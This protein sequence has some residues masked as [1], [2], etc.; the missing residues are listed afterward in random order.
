M[1][2]NSHDPSLVRLDRSDGFATITIDDPATR[3]AL[4]APVLAGLSA[5]CATVEGDADV[6][7]VVVRG[8]GDRVFV[9]GGNIAEVNAAVGGDHNS[10]GAAAMMALET[11]TKPV[12]AAINGHCLGGGLLVALTADLRVAV[13]KA[14]F[15]IPAVRLGVAYPQAGVDMVVREVGASQARHLLVTGDRIDA[16]RAAEIGLVHQVASPDTFDGAVHDLVTTLLANAPLSMAAGK[17]AVRVSAGNPATSPS[18][19]ADAIAAAWASADAVEG[20]AAFL[21]KRPAKFTGA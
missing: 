3:N 13:D 21:E 1:H 7:V 20:T 19:A 9:S 5:A 6:R 8:G 17:A 14:T 11:I 10:P 18:E 2:E 16:N 4:S 15:G 12:V